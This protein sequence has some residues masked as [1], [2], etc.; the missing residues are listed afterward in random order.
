MLHWQGIV[1][2][3]AEYLRGLVHERR[4]PHGGHLEAAHMVIHGDLEARVSF[5]LRL[6]GPGLRLLG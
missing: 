5:V 4:M 3:R 2:V 1:G 6:V